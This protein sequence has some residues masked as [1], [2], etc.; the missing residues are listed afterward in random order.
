[1]FYTE[2]IHTAKMTATVW[3]YRPL[4]GPSSENFTGGVS[5]YVS[6]LTDGLV[7]TILRIKP[8]QVSVSIFF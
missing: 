7:L 4:V 8:C 2:N 6:R 5:G 1:M 3:L